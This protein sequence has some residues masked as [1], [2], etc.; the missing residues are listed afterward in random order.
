M[1]TKVMFTD[2]DLDGSDLTD[3]QV[4]VLQFVC[5]RRTN[6]EIA[7]ML[8]ISPSAVEQRLQSVRR[9]FGVHSRADLARA[10]EKFRINS[11]NL[12]GAEYQVESSIPDGHTL[13]GFKE[14]GADIQ[15]VDIGSGSSSPVPN[16][17]WGNKPAI[18]SPL[19]EAVDRTA[20]VA[21]RI[22]A[23]TTA[24]ASIAL[25]VILIAKVAPALT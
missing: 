12:T 9:K 8:G 13:G 20:G 15:A 22:A 16:N 17:A 6:K 25:L 21:G 1:V 24:A 14:E 3:K 19:L 10:Y 5:D 11:V 4:E 18:S 7:L 2:A 23:I